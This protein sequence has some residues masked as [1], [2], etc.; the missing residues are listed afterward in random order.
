MVRTLIGE[1]VPNIVQ[2]SAEY[3]FGKF[4]DK[5]SAS[6]NDGTELSERVLGDCY[7]AMLNTITGAGM[8][9]N[10]EP[11]RKGG[12][13]FQ[14]A[15]ELLKPVG[16]AIIGSDDGTTFKVL[17]SIIRNPAITLSAEGF[18]G[19]ENTNMF[20]ANF[21]IK[22]SG[23]IDNSRKYMVAATSALDFNLF[24]SGLQWPYASRVIIEH[25]PYFNN[26][27][28]HV[29]DQANPNIVFAY[30]DLV[31]PEYAL[32]WARAVLTIYDAGPVI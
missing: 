11:E 32:L 10:N 30:P 31:Q 21:Q 9:P 17:S 6:T 25:N 18:V 12:S 24:V 2:P 13:Q 15:V 4:K 1:G 20:L 23:S 3:P 28:A 7:Q 5:T 26:K 19:N 22:K 27:P 8:T 29:S 14:K 16:V